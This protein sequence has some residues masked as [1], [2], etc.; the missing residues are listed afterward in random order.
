MGI[1]QHDMRW[2][3]LGQCGEHWVGCQK[4]GD[5]QLKWSESTMWI[6]TAS[7]FIWK[8]MVNCT[9]SY[10]QPS[11]LSHLVRVGILPGIILRLVISEGEGLTQEVSWR[12]GWREHLNRKPW[13]WSSRSWGVLQ[14][15][16]SSPI[17]RWWNGS[18]SCNY[19]QI[20]TKKWMAKHEII[21]QTNLV[22]PLVVCPFSHTHIFIYICMG[23]VQNTF[24]RTAL[25][26]SAN[27]VATAVPQWA[28]AEGFVLCWSDH[29]HKI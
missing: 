23:V 13:R 2:N 12:M 15:L 14:M 22:G 26:R 17:R 16:L 7:G 25:N 11:P 9:S 29:I 5:G 18:K 24:S 27:R 3:I 28:I 6:P 4:R 21:Q 8:T 1:D 20:P 10:C 19:P